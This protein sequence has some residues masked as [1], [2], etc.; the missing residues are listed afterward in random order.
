LISFCGD[1]LLPFGVMALEFRV[2]QYQLR[3]EFV[4]DGS[5]TKT[6]VTRCSHGVLDRANEVRVKIESSSVIILKSPVCG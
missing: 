6:S 4:A 1:E 2:D 3:V 5:R